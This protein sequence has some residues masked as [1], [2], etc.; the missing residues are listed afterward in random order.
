VV[1]WIVGSL[2]NTL[3]AQLGT[4][5]TYSPVASVVNPGGNGVLNSASLTA[6]FVNRNVSISLNATNVTQGNTFQMNGTSG[7]SAT[8]ARFSSGFT[9][10]TCT[11]TCTGPNQLGGGFAG[12]FAGTNAEA[13]GV[14]FHSGFGANGVI[15]VVGLKR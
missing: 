7:I 8:S 15:G 4:S 2:T 1:P 9:S 6:D 5:V 10:V 13:A 14:S 3:P 12:F 11:G